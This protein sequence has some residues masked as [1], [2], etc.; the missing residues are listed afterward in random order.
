MP[1]SP[2]PR[3]LG[4]RLRAPRAAVSCL[5]V[6]LM[7][8]PAAAQDPVGS[9]IALDRLEEGVR[10]DLPEGSRDPVPEVIPISGPWRLVGTAGGVRTWEAPIPVRLRS[11]H[12]RQPPKALK[13]LLKDAE[14]G[15]W[16]AP[17]ALKHQRGVR[18]FGRAASWELTAHALRVRR[19]TDAG[20]PPPGAYGVRFPSAVERERS[21]NRAESGLS[22]RDFVVRSLQLDDTTRHGLLLPAPSGATF[23]V[24][25]PA[26]GVLDLAP[27]LLPPEAADPAARSDGA[28]LIIRIR[29]GERVT[30]LQTVSLQ[31]GDPEPIR[32]DLDAWSGERVQLELLTHPAGSADYDYVFVT[33]P[34]IHVPMADPP[35]VVLVFIDTLR[36]DH[37]STYGYARET[38][39]NIDAWA[40]GAAV[41]E[42]ARSVAPWTL[43]SVRTMM[44]GHQ[45]E[46]WG[47][48]ETLQERFARAGWANAFLAG[49]IYLS[50]NFEGS[51]GW[52]EHRCVNWPSAEVQVERARAFLDRYPDR[53][54]FLLLHF[55]DAHLPYIE[56]VAWRR[57]FA[58]PRPDLFHSD[59]FHRG[60]I[61]KVED[62]LGEEGIAYLLGRYDNNIAYVDHHLADVLG[63]T[64][65]EDTVVV[66]ADHGEEF[67]DHG[68]FEHGHTLYDEVLRI[69][70][71]VRG[72]GI[73]SG[74]VDVPVSLIDV[75]PTL[76]RSAGLPHEDMAGWPLQDAADGSRSEAF[77]GRP[78]AFG[79]PLY[80]QRRWGVLVGTEKYTTSAGEDE[81]YDLAKDA[82]EQDDLLARPWEAPPVERWQELAAPLQRPVC[83]GIRLAP[84]RYRG[85]ADLTAEV[86]IPGGVAWAYAGDDP[87]MTS[88]ADVLVV[89][90][91]VRV[92]W[93]G[94][95][96][97]QREVFI[98][99][100]EDPT[101]VAR[102]T[103]V[104][105]Q[106]GAQTQVIPMATALPLDGTGQRLGRATLGGRTLDVTYAIIPAPPPEGGTI[107]GFDPEAAE[108]LAALGYV[109]EAG[110]PEEAGAGGGGT[111]ASDVRVPERCVV[112]P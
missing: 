88:A 59:T 62:R 58:G 11:I 54:A 112:A 61:M 47:Q 91:R 69:P 4:F 65:P 108:A 106:V 20:P 9:S 110:Q 23:D 7:S 16:G 78:T 46:A 1:T 48:V 95:Y 39:P 104:A 107:A 55:M 43:P 35:R 44:T 33:D 30:P 37:L 72:P 17:N 94:N 93:P 18:K 49:N 87:S 57:R 45:P 19:P 103:E 15:R 63:E 101:E 86:E 31:P 92:T 28:D 25:I 85:T 80:G 22:D 74:R 40:E 111:L 21:L 102:Q 27:M 36:A 73:P 14:T 51:S 99:P 71:I 2:T 13:V 3:P 90:D 26:G 38:S 75:A 64:G 24:E 96:S 52:S 42:Q 10:F 6:G 41:F 12:V 83:S 105:L 97:G 60:T 67:W 34:V 50:S 84:E 8:L 32:V 66:L 29:E 82:A 53:P 5:L 70:M 76:A 79:R 68:D 89:G 109:T 56:P 98:V 81:L 100:M 77:Q